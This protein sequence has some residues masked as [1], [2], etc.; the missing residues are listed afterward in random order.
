MPSRRPPKS[1]AA[2]KY[3]H[4]R[5]LRRFFDNGRHQDGGDGERQALADDS[6]DQ[7]R[8]RRIDKECDECRHDA[9]GEHGGH[10]PE[11][12]APVVLEGPGGN[13]ELVRLVRPAVVRKVK[14]IREGPA[15][16][17]APGRRAFPAHSTYDDGIKRCRSP[18]WHP[19]GCPR[20]STGSPRP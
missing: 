19:M 14:R 8:A 10:E 5:P 7:Q 20:R 11:R 4:A 9:P 3:Q 1:P 17:P 15:L 16:S 18:P 6:P 2:G 13:T 12:L